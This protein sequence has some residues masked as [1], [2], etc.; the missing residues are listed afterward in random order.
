MKITE[1]QKKRIKEIAQELF[2]DIVKH[3]PYTEL[4]GYLNNLGKYCVEVA[5]TYVTTNW[6]YG[7]NKLLD[8]IK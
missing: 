6:N 2:L 4:E 1:Q 3:Q 5:T 7:V 8:E